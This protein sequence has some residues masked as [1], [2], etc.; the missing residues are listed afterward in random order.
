M[1]RRNSHHGRDDRARRKLKKS[2]DGG[3]IT[4]NDVSKRVYPCPHPACQ[5]GRR[6]F[7]LDGVFSHL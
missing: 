1:L 7:N 6:T 3:R 2:L 5:D 4:A